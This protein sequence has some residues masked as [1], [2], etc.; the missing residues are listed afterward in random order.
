MPAV[1]ERSALRS[2]FHSCTPWY[3]PAQTVRLIIQQAPG[4]IFVDLFVS[5]ELFI[6]ADLVYCG[7]G[8]HLL[9]LH[10]GNLFI[11]DKFLIRCGPHFSNSSVSEGE[12]LNNLRMLYRVHRTTDAK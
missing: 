8:K 10:R 7:A 1:A 6:K 2:V 4:Y 12:R 3:H 5:A 11:C 9:D